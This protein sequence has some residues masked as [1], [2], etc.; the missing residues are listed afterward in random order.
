MI[1][2]TRIRVRSGQLSGLLTEEKLEAGMRAE[3]GVTQMLTYVAAKRMLGVGEKLTS[4]AQLS[5]HP[6]VLRENRHSLESDA[7]QASQES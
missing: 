6:D 4:L 3:E 7:R 1:G 2:D 5:E